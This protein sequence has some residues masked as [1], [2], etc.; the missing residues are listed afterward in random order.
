[1]TVESVKPRCQSD[2]SFANLDSGLSNEGYE[3]EL[4]IPMDMLG[5][6]L[7]FAIFDVDDQVQRNVNTVVATYRVANA[8]RL[9]SLRLPTPEIE[10]IVAGMG[11]NNSRIQ[12]VDRNGRVLQSVGDIQSAT[13][14]LLTSAPDEAPINKY[15]LYLQNKILN[16]QK[17]I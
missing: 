16:K 9:G 11:H 7:G 13:G 3:I 6:R 15:W 2:G 14:L 10:R 5:D 8:E 17:H 12:V 4:Q 1:M